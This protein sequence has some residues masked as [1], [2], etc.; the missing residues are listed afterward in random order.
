LTL[1]EN[2]LESMTDLPYEGGFL[3][4]YLGKLVYPNISAT[5]L[6]VASWVHTICAHRSG[7]PDDGHVA[8]AGD[9]NRTSNGVAGIV[10]LSLS[11]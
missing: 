7:F 8:F 4:D 9:G 2:W 10:S 5:I 3:L 6:T 11:N 1:L